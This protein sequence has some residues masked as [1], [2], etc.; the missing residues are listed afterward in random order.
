MG[1]DERVLWD[2]WVVR[3]CVSWMGMS[4]GRWHINPSTWG[5]TGMAL[6]ASELQEEG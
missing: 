5:L 6:D 1:A 3:E 2:G 4:S